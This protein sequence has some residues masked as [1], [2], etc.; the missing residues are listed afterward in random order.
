[1]SVNV[2][3]C[4]DENP[5][6]SCLL[7]SQQTAVASHQSSPAQP[8]LFATVHFLPRASV[9]CGAADRH[10]ARRLGITCVASKPKE[11]LAAAQTVAEAA[12]KERIK[13]RASSFIK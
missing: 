13:A 10:D 9:E 1:M 3:N 2:K 4:K 7:N 6:N 8:H 11:R 5:V 12:K